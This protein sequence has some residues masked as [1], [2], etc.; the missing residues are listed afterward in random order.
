M[1]KYGKAPEGYEYSAENS[2]IENGLR[3]WEVM[4]GPDRGGVGGYALDAYTVYENGQIIK[5]DNPEDGIY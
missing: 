5:W 1:N 4:F 3:Y 2:G